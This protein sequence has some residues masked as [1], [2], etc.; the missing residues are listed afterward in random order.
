MTYGR[1][2][3]IE[4][5]YTRHGTLPLIGNFCVTTGPLIACNLGPT[6]TEADFAGPIERTVATDPGASWVFVWIT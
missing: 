2:Q 4:F 5:E 1:C 6:R 3:R